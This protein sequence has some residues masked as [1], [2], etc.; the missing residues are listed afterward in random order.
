MIRRSP[1]QSRGQ[2]SVKALFLALALLG[3]PLAAAPATQASV[4]VFAAA[5]LTDALQQ[6]ADSYTK[7][8]GVEVKL[9]FAASSALAH[10][11]ESGAPADIFVSADRDWMDFL[12]THG[13][14]RAESR[15]DLLSNRLALVAP[16]ASKLSIKIEPHFPLS[17]ALGEGRWVTGDPDSVPVGRYTQAALQHL[18]V[19]D[20]LVSRLVRADN[21]R[22]ALV[23]VARG[24]VSFGIVYETDAMIEPKVRIV[25]IFPPDLHPPIVY[26]M[27]LTKGASAQAAAFIHYMR[28][29]EA[30][31]VFHKLGFTTLGP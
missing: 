8:S 18:D 19:W 2:N 27:A 28:G 5:S 16:A 15:Q 9:S 17:A 4:V 22:A 10:Q 21:V 11:I 31:A 12:Q 14:I 26:P 23:L 1:Y 24:E 25:D 29:P 6:V 20:A 3:Q 13:L 7:A 30:S